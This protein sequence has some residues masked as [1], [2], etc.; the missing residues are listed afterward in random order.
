MSGG[1]ITGG[2]RFVCS[3]APEEARVVWESMER[4]SGKKVSAH[5][6]KTDGRDVNHNTVTNWYKNGWIKKSPGRKFSNPLREMEKLLPLL[7]G[8]T[9]SDIYAQFVKDSA[10]GDIHENVRLAN[11]D[12]ALFLRGS[13][14]TAGKLM[15][16]MM[17]SNPE[18]FSQLMKACCLCLDAVN[19]TYQK[20]AAH[21]HNLINITAEKEDTG[22]ALKDA[23]SAW[24]DASAKQ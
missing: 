12:M 11:M 3:V 2:N 22:E 23:L 16:T 13:I 7:A 21:E 24:E 17:S 5:F 10:T 4:P 1:R 9:T 14:S 19:T 18:G 6:K 20:V 8:K 15:A